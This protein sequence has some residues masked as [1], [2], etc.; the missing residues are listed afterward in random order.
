MKLF[1]PTHNC[2]FWAPL[3]ALWFFARM[4]FFS[5]VS[6][7]NETIRKKATTPPDPLRWGKTLVGRYDE[8]ADP[9]PFCRIQVFPSSA[10][11][12]DG[13]VAI[14]KMP[15]GG[16]TLVKQGEN[17]DEGGVYLEKLE[18]EDFNLRIFVGYIGI[19]QIISVCSALRIENW[20]YLLILIL[21]VF[22]D[23]SYLFEKY[24]LRFLES[25]E[26]DQALTK[27]MKQEHW[28][29]RWHTFQA[30]ELDCNWEMIIY[31]YTYIPIY[32]YQLYH[33]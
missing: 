2:F 15:P 25:K 33:P 31:I 26:I 11:T 29:S 8:S 24:V 23:P 30:N 14:L 22:E 10:P 6:H 19:Y 12:A 9:K 28:K 20:C 5:F 3:C 27:T 32:I 18:C 17:C 7:S 4:F 13:A 16:S 21:P 1:H